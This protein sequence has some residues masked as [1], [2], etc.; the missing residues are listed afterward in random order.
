MTDAKI[1]LS[2]VVKLVKTDGP[3]LIKFRG[4][5]CSAIISYEEYK[6]IEKYLYVDKANLSNPTV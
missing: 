5:L 3:Q 2:K 1:Q 4:D 6:K